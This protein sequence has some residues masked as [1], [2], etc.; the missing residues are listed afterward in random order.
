MSVVDLNKHLKLSLWVKVLV[1]AKVI[2][3][4]FKTD[5]SPCDLSTCIIFPVKAV[6]HSDIYHTDKSRFRKKSMNIYNYIS[7]ELDHR[8]T[9]VIV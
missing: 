7:S 8:L 2:Q 6:F 5:T 1:P 3:S 4:L 9:P